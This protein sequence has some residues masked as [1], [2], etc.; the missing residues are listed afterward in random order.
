M[1]PNVALHPGYGLRTST[2]GK[3]VAREQIH[4]ISCSAA[5]T[6]LGLTLGALTLG[7]CS[8]DLSLNNLTLAPKPETMA[9]NSDASGQAWARGTFERPISATDL[10]AGDGQCSASASDAPSGE[11]ATPGQA[12]PV[13]PM[14]GAIV[15]RMTEC[16][17]IRRAGPVEKIELGA[18]ERG[19][20]SLVLTYLHGSSPGVYRFVGGRLV[21]IERAP[22]AP[23]DE[24][25]PH[26]PTTNAKKPA[27]S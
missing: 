6:A 17:V 7:A 12:P 11:S 4:R 1:N 26:K 25:K 3:D 9:R 19:E 10:V 16:D 13:A 24:G 22:G 20:R 2:K 8:A 27:G 18:N 5:V 14:L 15:L 21:S 23:A